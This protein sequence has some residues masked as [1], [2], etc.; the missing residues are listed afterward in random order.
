MFF[1]SVSFQYLFLSLFAFTFWS[2]ISVAGGSQYDYRV[3]IASDLSSLSVDIYFNNKAEILTLGNAEAVALTQNLRFC[4]ERKPLHRQ[5]NRLYLESAKSACLHYDFNL[6]GVHEEGR[7]GA[8]LADDNCQV[9]IDYWLWLPTLKADTEIR[10]QIN[11]SVPWE[12]AESP[13]QYKFSLSPESGEAIS[14]FGYFEN[15]EI[16]IPGAKLRVS[17]LKGEL[18]TDTEKILSWLRAAATNVTL[19]YGRF[20]NPLPQIIVVPVAK[21]EKT[22]HSP[23]PFGHV[24]RDGGE[25]V[26]FFVDQSRPLEDFLDDW[27]ATHEFSHLML[28]YINSEQKW[29]SEGFASYYQNVLLARSGMYTAEQ[30]WQD[31]YAGFQ[32]AR[33]ESK[34]ISPNKAGTMRLWDARM[35]VYWSGAALALMADVKLRQLSQGQES[36]DTV[37]GKLQACCLPSDK[38]WNG[39]EFF[40]KLDELSSYKVFVA[41]YDTYADKPGIPDLSEEFRNLGIVVINGKVHLQKKAPD[42]AIRD[43]IMQMNEAL[44]WMAGSKG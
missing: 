20:P 7:F 8:S 39:R 16:L 9:P 10:V 33:K 38:M 30:A 37:L 3:S 29:I 11:V 40:A 44:V 21:K 26:Q 41:L 27:T 6:A 25:A 36:L 14:V 31:L 2:S 18:P 19:A 35:M 23:V 32:R 24:I 28:P 43:A 22:S 42:I 15:R 5:G 12:P 17:L 34:N 4:D 13:N 1:R